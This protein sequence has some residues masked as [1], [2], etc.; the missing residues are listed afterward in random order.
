MQK[1]KVKYDLFMRLTELLAALIF[2]I[3]FILFF[4][5]YD[6]LP[7][8]IPKHFNIFGEPD[9]FGSKSFLWLLPILSFIF[10]AGFT[11]LA[12]Y[13]HKMNYP[14]AITEENAYEKYKLTIKFL[15]V[16]KVLFLTLFLNLLYETIVIGL[17][18]KTRLNIPVFL[19]LL[20]M[21]FLSI[22]IFI[23]RAVKK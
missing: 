23:Y 22:G 12:R 19:A 20:I 9:S 15:G 8:I 21:I 5:Y 4:A 3:T 7:E 11:L 2:V 13:P 1:I 10:Y 16:I 6:T 14:V 18:E 17:N